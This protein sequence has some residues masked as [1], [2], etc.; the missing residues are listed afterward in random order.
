MDE[1][2]TRNVPAYVSVLP[3]KRCFT[4]AANLCNILPLHYKAEMF[5]RRVPDLC[6]SDPEVAGQISSKCDSKDG[7]NFNR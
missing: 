2:K 4:V 1:K 3:I 5:Q 6:L 7:E